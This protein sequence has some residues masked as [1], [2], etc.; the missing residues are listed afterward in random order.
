MVHYR[1]ATHSSKGELLSVTYNQLVLDHVIL[2][3]LIEIQD[4]K[5]K[6]RKEYGHLFRQMFLDTQEL[7]SL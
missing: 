4:Y 2:S 5:P 1:E 3:I 6:T 7:E